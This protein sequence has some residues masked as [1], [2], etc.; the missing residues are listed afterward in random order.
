MKKI[1]IPLENTNRKSKPEW[2]IWLEA[3]IRNIR[4]TGKNY[5][6]KEKPWN[7]LGHKENSNTGKKWQYN[8]KK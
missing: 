2:K 6:T 7:I 4:K 3:Q 8:S 1:G 5:K